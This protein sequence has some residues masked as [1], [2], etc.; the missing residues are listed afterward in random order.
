MTNAQKFSRGTPVHVRA[1]ME[2]E[3]AALLPPAPPQPP[4]PVLRVDVADRGVGIASKD[5]VRI[6]APYEHADAEQARRGA[7]VGAALL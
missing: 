7:A 3:P 1:A 4:R 6:F 5:I 2:V